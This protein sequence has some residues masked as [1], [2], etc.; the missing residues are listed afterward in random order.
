[1]L[2]NIQSSAK[3]HLHLRN[4]FPTN[5]VYFDLCITASVKKYMLLFQQNGCA[6]KNVCMLV[7]K[8]TYMYYVRPLSDKKKCWLS[9]HE[10]TEASVTMKSLEADPPR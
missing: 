8:K 1:M 10:K 4:I 7:K 6:T 2:H 5:F 3:K 9:F